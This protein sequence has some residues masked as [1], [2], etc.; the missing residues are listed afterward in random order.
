[1]EL[2]IQL[3]LAEGE[4]IFLNNETFCKL[5]ISSLKLSFFYLSMVFGSS[6]LDF[7]F[8]PIKQRSKQ[9]CKSI[10]RTL[11]RHHQTVVFCR[12]TH[13]LCCSSHCISVLDHWRTEGLSH[14]Q[15]QYIKTKLFSQHWPLWTLLTH[16]PLWAQQDPLGILQN[17]TSRYCKGLLSY[18]KDNLALFFL[19]SIFLGTCVSTFHSLGQDNCSQENKPIICISQHSRS[20][21]I[22]LRISINV[23]KV[24]ISS[25]TSQQIISTSI[26]LW[27]TKFL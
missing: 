18:L 15:A 17:M 10:L 21:G 7:F 27:G 4:F 19:F 20:K 11:F 12:P 13:L 9:K 25:G 1:M 8:V 5:I 3:N 24:G 23:W 22:A 14:M 6:G 16:L 26:F 2:V